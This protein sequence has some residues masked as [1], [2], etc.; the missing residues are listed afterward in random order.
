MS[1]S[2]ERSVA[3][4][5]RLHHRAQVRF[6]VCGRHFALVPAVFTF[7]HSFLVNIATRASDNVPV[8]VQSQVIDV[9]AT[10]AR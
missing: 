10:V 2:I 6:I 9:S 3:F 8:E 4:R 7:R 5:A 1:E